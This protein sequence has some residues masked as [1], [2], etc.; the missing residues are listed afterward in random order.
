M[1]TL[2]PFVTAADGEPDLVCIVL[3]YALTAMAEFLGD[4][5][6]VAGLLQA[7]LSVT[8]PL[9]VSIGTVLLAR[10]QGCQ[11]VALVVVKLF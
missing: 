6:P 9:G 11:S 8:M 7:V 5:L 10:T 2:P 4:P 1:M 3:S